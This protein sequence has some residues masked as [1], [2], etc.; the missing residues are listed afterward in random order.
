MAKKP[1]FGAEVTD[2]FFDRAKVIA[3]MD[4]KTAKVMPRV[5]AFLRQ[6]GR[7]LIRTRKRISSPGEPASGH[8]GVYKRGIA[9]TF[10]PRTK[11]VVVGPAKVFEKKG[12]A[13]HAL[14]FSGPSVN[15]KG[16]EIEIHQARP[17]MGP[18]LHIEM[19]KGTIPNEFRGGLEGG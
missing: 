19:E 1:F 16:Q 18:A 9:F 5:G 10:Y 11:S 15:F 8:T 13:P 4:K 3:A 7:R 6:T 2:L 17:L 12:D 14:E